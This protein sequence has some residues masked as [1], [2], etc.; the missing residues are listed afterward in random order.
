MG[1]IGEMDQLVSIEKNG[2]RVLMTSQL[3]ESLGTTNKHLSDNFTNNKDRYREGKHFFVLEGEELQEFKLAYPKISDTLKFTSILYLW[4]VKGAW[5]HT[6]SLNTNEA[7]DAYEM[8]VDDYY[9]K[10]DQPQLKSMSELEMIALIAQKA[11][12]KEKADAERDRKIASIENSV[13]ILTEN[14]TDTPDHK[15]VTETVNQYARW[16]RLGHNEVYNQIYDI[17]QS[18]HGIDVRQRVEN[19]RRNI[20]S[21]RIKKTGK[22]YS[23]ST[24]KKKVNGI[25]IMVRIGVLDKFNSILTGLLAKEKAKSKIQLIK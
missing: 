6:K 13:T 23:G 4:T 9:E 12:E 20:Q 18:R 24:L 25:D 8:L 15:K 3:A 16:T 19:E 22:S 2:Q 17:L 10:Q 11:V 7:W 5:H 14:L 1:G 21:E